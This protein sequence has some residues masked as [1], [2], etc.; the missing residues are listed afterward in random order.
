MTSGA[1]MPGD[2]RPQKPPEPDP[3]ECCQSGCNPCVYDRYWEALARYE[4][5]LQ[6]WEARRGAGC[7]T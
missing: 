2:E 6:A 3:L 4:E 7:G 1:A 5:A